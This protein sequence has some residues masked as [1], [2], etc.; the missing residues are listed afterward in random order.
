MF[1]DSELSH[2]ASKYLTL[3]ITVSVLSDTQ[4]TS[5]LTQVLPVLTLELS[6]LDTRVLSD[7]QVT[8]ES[9]PHSSALFL[10]A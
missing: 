2:P 1:E 7:T 4:V 8:L 5:L 10:D 3:S 9:S 6:L